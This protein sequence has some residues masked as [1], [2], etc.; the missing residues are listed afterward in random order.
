MFIVKLIKQEGKL[1]YSTDKAKLSYQI[2]LDKL[3]EGQEVEMFI[4]LTSDNGSVAQLAKVHACIRALAKEAGYSFDEMKLLIKKAS[5]LCY[6]IEDVE[7]CKSF[8]ECSKEDLAGAIEACIAIG[9][10]NYNM[11]LT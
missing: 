3:T 4:G 10:D 2:F 1:I 7:I 5:G 9:R 8:G 6:T 11:N